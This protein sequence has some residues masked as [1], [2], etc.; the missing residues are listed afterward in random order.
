MSFPYLDFPKVQESF[1]RHEVLHNITGLWDTD[2]QKQ[3]NLDKVS[4]TEL[5]IAVC[6]I[7]VSYWLFPYGLLE[8]I[9]AEDDESGDNAL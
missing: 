3:L 9:A 6:F 5:Q 8:A 2:I 4:A 1:V 7:A